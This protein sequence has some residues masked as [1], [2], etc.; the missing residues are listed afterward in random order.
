MNFDNTTSIRGEDKIV[1]TQRNVD[2]IQLLSP[3]D[4]VT[5]KADKDEVLL[6]LDGCFMTSYL[7][8]IIITVI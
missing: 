2:R 8:N 7:V 5:Q 3:A 6:R 1:I 4:I